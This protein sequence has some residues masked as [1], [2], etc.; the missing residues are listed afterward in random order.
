MNG[1]V[2]DTVLRQTGHVRRFC[3]S[4]D[5]LCDLPDTTPTS[6]HTETHGPQKLWPQG[7]T[8]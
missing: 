5:F 3:Q 6:S 7:L 2:A 8:V 1:R 4:V